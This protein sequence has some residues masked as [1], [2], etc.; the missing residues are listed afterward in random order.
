M[1]NNKI[2]GLG[3]DLPTSKIQLEFRSV[4][5]AGALTHVM[6]FAGQADYF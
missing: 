2:Q 6:P 4:T 1:A 3:V 5:V